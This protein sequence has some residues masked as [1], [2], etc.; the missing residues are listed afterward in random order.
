MCR[1]YR[2]FNITCPSSAGS[3]VQFN[4]KV[5]VKQA[6]TETVFTLS[7]ML[8]ETAAYVSTDGLLGQKYNL[9]STSSCH[10][11]LIEPTALNINGVELRVLLLVRYLC[12]SVFSHYSVCFRTDGF[13]GWKLLLIFSKHTQS[14]LNQLKLFVKG[15]DRNLLTQNFEIDL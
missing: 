7:Q 13:H 10:A 2:G 14:L 15:K 4:L 11:T 1:E 9:G 8:V 5:T 12:H 6:V 3:H